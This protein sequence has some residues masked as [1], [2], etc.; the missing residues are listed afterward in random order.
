MRF[1]LSNKRA[2]IG[3]KIT[4]RVTAG[5]REAIAKVATELDGRKLGTDG[6]R[7]AEVHYERIFEQVGGGGPG[8]DHV[9]RV[10]ATDTEGET[11]VASRR[12]TD[13]S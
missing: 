13:V 7:P 8:Q 11:R 2:L 10:R 4:V 5:A 12:W 6:L 3:H 9:L 1:S